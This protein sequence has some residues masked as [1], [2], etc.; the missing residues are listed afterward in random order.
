MRI[1]SNAIFA[2]KYN[3]LF[4]W[5]MKHKYTEFTLEGGR[6]AWKSRVVPVGRRIMKEIFPQ[7]NALIIRKRWT[8]WAKENGREVGSGGLE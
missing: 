8:K 2:K 3:K 7:F 1:K 5:I 4:R 6:G